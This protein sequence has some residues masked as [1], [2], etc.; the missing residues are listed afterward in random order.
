MFTNSIGYLLKMLNIENT[1]SK[2]NRYRFANNFL[3]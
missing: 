2:L 3:V 1:R